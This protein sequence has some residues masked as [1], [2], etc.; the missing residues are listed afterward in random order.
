MEG[1]DRKGMLTKT[2][3]EFLLGEK[4]YESKQGR[5]D[6]RQSI[7]ERAYGSILDFELLYNQ[8]D[9]EEFE[10]I[11]GWQDRGDDIELY[12]GVR[13]ALQ[14]LYKVTAKSPEIHFEDVLEQAVTSAEYDLNGQL[15]N[16]QFGMTPER[17][18][19]LTTQASE[20]IQQGRIG[21]LTVAEMRQFLQ[22][23]H[24]SGELDAEL[25]SDYS[26]WRHGT[27]RER[28]KSGDIPFSEWRDSDEE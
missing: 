22:F 19:V 2:D 1:I 11:F 28:P 14:F 9:D 7:R 12:N 5:Y 25:P 10:K 8:L 4:V 13:Y 17:P 21:E 6:R 3:R 23:Y 27:S 15:V 26:A 18:E 24:E 16:V 20:K